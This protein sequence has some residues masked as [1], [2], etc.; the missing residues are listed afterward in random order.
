MEIRAL[1][2]ECL[3]GHCYH[4]LAD[5]FFGI[6][7]NEFNLIIT[8]TPGIGKTYFLFFLMYLLRLKDP[9]AVVVLYRH[10]EKAWYLFSKEKICV[11]HEGTKTAIIIRQ[12]YLED[13]KTWY[14]I[15]TAKPLRVRAKT[16]LVSYPNVKIYKEFL[17][18]KTNIRFMP[19]WSK[20]DIDICRQ[21]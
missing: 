14:L 3:S 21:V 2:Q 18:S 10:L 17:K 4:H 8:G 6:S 9:N 7:E 20:L 16:L 15:D 12:K 11:A 19:V 5:V 1:V 13:P